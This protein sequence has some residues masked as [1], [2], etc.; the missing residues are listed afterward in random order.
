MGFQEGGFFIF[1]DCWEALLDKRKQKI[2][3]NKEVW[4]INMWC[5]FFPFLVIF[6]DT[7]QSL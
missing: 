3:Q 2:L 4:V 1:N 7:S 5:F 6:K